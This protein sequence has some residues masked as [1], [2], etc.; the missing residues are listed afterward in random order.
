MRSKIHNISYENL[1]FPYSPQQLS[2]L[3]EA[4][5]NYILNE[6]F[7]G[8]NKIMENLRTNPSIGIYECDEKS[9]EYRAKIFGMNTYPINPA[10]N[11]LLLFLE[12]LN[13]IILIILIVFA[14]ISM[15]LGL[16]FPNS[17][18]DRK[19]GWIEGFTI[20]IAVFIVVS[21]TSINDFMK[22]RKFRS[23]SKESK[24]IMINV[25]RNGNA[26]DILI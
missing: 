10:K 16:I 9:L 23:L 24:R 19:Y 4:D 5:N 17:A 20:L 15:L 1:H 14:L 12:N 7:G 13:D 25:T 2:K 18:Q 3:I 26:A 22:E 11:I 8:I 6:E 21:V